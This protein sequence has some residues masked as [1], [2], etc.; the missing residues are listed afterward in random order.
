MTK[1]AAVQYPPVYYDLAKGIERAVEIIEEAASD[2]IECLVFS[3]AWLTGYPILVWNYLPTNG[4]GILSDIYRRMFEN[5]VDLSRN[6]LKPVCDAAKEHGIVVVMAVNE[7]ESEMS[8]STLY[9]TMV[10]I[11]ATGKILNVHRKVMPTGPER[12]VWGFGDATG[13]NVVDTAV[14]RVGGLLC[15]ENYMPL[16]RAA[17]YAQNVEIYCAPTA[18]EGGVW[19]SAMRHIGR[20]GSCFVVSVA[21][22]VEVSDLPKDLPSYAEYA[23]DDDWV[24]TGNGIICDP[25][26]DIIAGPMPKEKGLLTADIDVGRVREARR[27]FDVMGHYSRP[28]IFQLSVNRSKMPPVKFESRD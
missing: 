6:D 19:H 5:S 1:I 28:D 9:N 2:G 22:T 13:I 14:G 21:P 4:F 27:A 23:G 12:M 7:R 10:I 16:A 15:W 18:A 24:A 17:V 25:M 3:E 20:E 11:D 8:A 26:G